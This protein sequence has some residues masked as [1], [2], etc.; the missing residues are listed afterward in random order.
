MD[1]TFIFLIISSDD[2]AQ[3]SKMKEISNKYHQL[4]RE[5]IKHFYIE[6]KP[7]LENDI[8]EEG[9][10]LYIKGNES[11]HPG[12][13]NKTK[14][15]LEY[16]NGK[17]NY[18]YVVRTNLS[19][20]WDLP[21]LLLLEKKLPKTNIAIG[22]L[23]FNTFISGTS[24]IIS[25][26]VARNITPLLEYNIM[27]YDDVYISTIIHRMYPIADISDY[28]YNTFYRIDNDVTVPFDM[29]NNHFTILFYR[30]KNQDRDID[31][32]LFRFLL[33]HIYD[34]T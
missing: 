32:A 28:G 18:K 9:H 10:H 14:K 4:F 13:L 17:Y 2:V 26:D 34:K 29:S 23:P 33:K 11:I 21:Q 27:Q 19:S 16:I 5:Q 1:Y 30:I 6:L 8:I 22:H 15:A 7:T 24:I 25:S 20:F 3:Y 31:I 12:I